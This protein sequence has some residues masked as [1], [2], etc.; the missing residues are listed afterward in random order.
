MLCSTKE[1]YFYRLI[2]RSNKADRISRLTKTTKSSISLMWRKRQ[3]GPI[4]RTRFTARITR[5]A[6]VTESRKVKSTAPNPHFFCRRIEW[7]KSS[8]RFKRLSFLRGWSQKKSLRNRKKSSTVSIL[9]KQG[10]GH[11]VFSPRLECICSQKWPVAKS[12]RQAA[13][14]L[15]SSQRWRHQRCNLSLMIRQRWSEPSNE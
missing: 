2:R 6:V 10:L 9:R 7:R 3:R 8:I 11:R 13:C 12:W 14:Q 5:W 1:N 15:R 4:F